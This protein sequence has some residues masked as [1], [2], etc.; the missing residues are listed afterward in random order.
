MTKS[1]LEESSS[2]SSRGNEAQTS[3]EM[4]DSVGDQSLLTSAV[5]VLQ[6]RANAPSAIAFIP[7][8]GG[9]KRLAR[10]NTRLFFGHPLMAYTIAA[11]RHIF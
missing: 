10:K 8:R 7:A 11:A 9:S 6:T 3:P 4:N 2:S 1:V 5:T